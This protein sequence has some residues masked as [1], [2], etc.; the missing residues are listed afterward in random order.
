MRSPSLVLAAALAASLSAQVPAPT[1]VL[2]AFG[3]KRASVQSLTLPQAAGRVAFEVV[4]DLDGRRAV[5]Q[6]LEHDVRAD[7]FQ[8][9][10][11]DGQTIRALP[12]P[13]NT[14]YQG[15][16]AGKPDSL[17]AA[18]L[19]NGQLTATMRI[20][21]ATWGIEPISRKIAT[22][23]TTA[24]VVYRQSDVILPADLSCG[25]DG[26]AT[27]APVLG[28]PQAGN[29]MLQEAEIA[30][31]CDLEYYNRNGSNTTS[32][33]NAATAIINGI[34]AI[35]TRDVEV[36]YRIT[37]ILVRTVR[38]YTNTDMRQ[39]LP[40]FRARWNSQ[41][42]S[43]RRDLAHLMTGKGSFSGIVGIAYLGV[44]CNLPNAYGVNKAFSSATTN[45]GLVAHEAGHNW[46]S[47]HCD[48]S[49]PCNIMCSGLGGCNRN[50]TSF[51][52]FA[53][54]AIISFRNSRSCLTPV[55]GGQ[56][57][58]FQRFGQGCTGSNGTPDHST[59]GI[60]KIANGG[61]YS[62]ASGQP[63]ANTSMV[64]GGSNTRFGTLALPFDM[65][66]IGAASC[67][68]YCDHAAVFP[69]TVNAFGGATVTINYPNDNAL[70]GVPFYTQFFV[71]D[72]A[73]NSLGI[74]TTPGQRTI[75]GN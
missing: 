44:V 9:L 11:D 21:G 53:R 7:D 17:V 32:T 73:A 18:S 45:V 10:V 70:V 60:P 49:S 12:R 47:N 71:L 15:E 6:L 51:G 59:F 48:S 41:H 28:G 40:E 25:L 23:P 29:M 39:L 69:R 72:S 75:L 54:N 37:T 74:V 46:N 55:G 8:L 1:P 36:T 3:L 26:N 5:L 2:D 20:D 34:D 67:F 62:L 35:Y 50:L 22:M 64:L 43:I 57:G 42:G 13:V 58:S 14:T 52:T 38:T 19:V 68:V 63:S 65:A 24:H 33:Q 27:S 4:V 16:V 30:L 31:D 61:F 66:P 56:P